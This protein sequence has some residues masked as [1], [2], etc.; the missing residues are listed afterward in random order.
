MYSVCRNRKVSSLL[1]LLLA[2]GSLG[3]QVASDRILNANREPR[4]WL[5]Y[6]GGYASQRHS[7]LTKLNREN[8]GHLALK[9]VYRPRYMDK[10]E[11]TPLVVDGVLYTV[12]NSEVV[13][14]D[15]AT[16]RTFW[17]FRYAVPPESNQYVMVVKGL[18]IAGDTLYW[19]TYDGHLIAI[20]AKTGLALWN[21]VLVDW[22][23]G[24][25][26]NVAPL[27]V[28][29]KLIF[30]PATNED[31]ANCW[32]AAYDLKTGNELWRFYTAPT[33]ADEPAAKTWKGDSWSTAAARSG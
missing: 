7:L 21:K 23:K 11:A 9:W 10:M 3:A 15:A 18:A 32:V 12:Q 5:T 19:P 4:N 24:Y 25:Q 2:A 13:A 31:G 30:G 17:T 8:V 6:G 27:V 22:H 1:A 28:K 16:G 29:D 33:S 20:D 14:M 26:L